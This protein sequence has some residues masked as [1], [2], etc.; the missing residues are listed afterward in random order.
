MHRTKL[1]PRLNQSKKGKLIATQQNYVCLKEREHT[2]GHVHLNELEIFK[3]DALFFVKWL[4][5][6]HL[7]LLNKLF[8]DQNTKQK[9][10]LRFNNQQKQKW[11][12]R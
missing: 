12:I 10:T 6:I 2:V 3:S 1:N 7:F 9:Q 5:Q 11:I 4:H 8:A